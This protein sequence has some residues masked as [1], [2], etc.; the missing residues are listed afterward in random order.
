MDNPDEP[1]NLRFLRRLVTVLTVV[2]IGGVLVVIL[3][4]VTRLRDAG[5]D[6][7]QAIT[8]PD[9]TEAQAFTQGRGWYAVV[10]QDN[11]ILIFDQISGKLRQ[12]VVIE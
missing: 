10:T 6:M 4:L 5:P 8:L 12:T 2:M 1:A 11:K 3:L 9:G 7:P